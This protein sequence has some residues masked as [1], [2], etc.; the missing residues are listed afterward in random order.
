M[1]FDKRGHLNWPKLN[2]SDRVASIIENALSLEEL[3]PNK[4]RK[5]REFLLD[6]LKYNPEWRP[7]PAEVLMHEFLLR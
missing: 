1:Y 4:H 5:F 6:I 2:N 7:S 3:I